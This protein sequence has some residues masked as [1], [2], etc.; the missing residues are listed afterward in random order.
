M[1]YLQS[2]RFDLV[3]DVKSCQRKENVFVAANSQRKKTKLKVEFKLILHR[4]QKM[5]KIFSLYI[6]ID[7]KRRT[8]L[9]KP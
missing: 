4:L 2:Y 7:I 8:G 3:S 1:A 5:E 9:I 6:A